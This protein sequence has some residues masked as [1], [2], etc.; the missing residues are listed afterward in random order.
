[1]FDELSDR[2]LLL[3][4]GL[5]VF[6]V[7]RAGDGGDAAAL[8]AVRGGEALVVNIAEGAAAE[9]AAASLE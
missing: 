5:R 4:S 9:V 1:M 3:V 8:V 2:F 6:D 7:M